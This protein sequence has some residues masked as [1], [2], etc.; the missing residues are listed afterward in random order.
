M[1]RMMMIAHSVNAG[2]QLRR[3]LDHA[4]KPSRPILSAPVYTGPAKVPCGE[5]L[6]KCVCSVM[7]HTGDDED[8]DDCALRKCW[9]S[10]SKTTGSCSQAKQANSQCTCVHWTCEGAMR[11]KP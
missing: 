9:L 4:V 1:M 7:Q 10:A 5:N 3:Q 11:R 6:K 8:D 2:F